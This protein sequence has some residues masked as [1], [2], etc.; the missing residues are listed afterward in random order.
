M[1]LMI[2]PSLLYYVIAIRH[3]LF[4]NTLEKEIVYD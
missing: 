3:T 4:I 2:H 1:Y